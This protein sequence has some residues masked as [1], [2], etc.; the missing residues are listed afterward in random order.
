MAFI[1]PKKLITTFIFRIRL[2]LRKQE[3]DPNEQMKPSTEEEMRIENKFM[4][5][6]K[7]P[8]LKDPRLLHIIL[9]FHQ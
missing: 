6:S 9:N 4:E 3:N 5:L 2:M 8:S 7:T 1:S